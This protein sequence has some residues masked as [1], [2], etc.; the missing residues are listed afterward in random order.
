MK[1]MRIFLMVTLILASG[2]TVLAASPTAEKQFATLQSADSSSQSL[3]ELRKSIDTLK[4][5]V[6]RESDEAYKNL[7]EARL[8]RAWTNLAAIG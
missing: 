3:E 7:A 5:A 1:R 8:G 4:D 6:V 2:F